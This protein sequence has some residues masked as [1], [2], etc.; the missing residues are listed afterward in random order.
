MVSFPGIF[1]NQLTDMHTINAGDCEIKVSPMSYVY[2]MLGRDT[3]KKD[4][5]DLLC[6]LYYYAQAC[7]S[8]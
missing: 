5:K 3:A 1:A 6:A 7:S 4:L 2:E 8:Y